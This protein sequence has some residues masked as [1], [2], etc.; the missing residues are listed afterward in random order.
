MKAMNNSLNKMLPKKGVGQEDE[1]KVANKA[2]K[3]A[4]K[5]VF[6]LLQ[7]QFLVS[8][9]SQELCTSVEDLL[10]KFPSFAEADSS[11]LD[12]LVK[13]YNFMI[14]ALKLIEADN[15]KEK[16]LYI[17]GVLSV[18]KAIKYITGTGQSVFVSRRVE[19]YERLGNITPKPSKKGTKRS[20]SE[21]DS[22]SCDSGASSKRS[23]S[24][25]LS[26]YSSGYSSEELEF[27]DDIVELLHAFVAPH[28]GASSST[29]ASLPVEIAENEIEIDADLLDSACE[30]FEFDPELFDL[31]D[32]SVSL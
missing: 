18:G 27:D 19:I 32:L 13:F 24:S 16:L 25:D 6:A 30:L 29:S 26:G 2:A 11:E 28:E 10:Q 1:R 4:L 7:Y 14:A 31:E 8:I 9:N 21:T 12:L 15:N 17:C 20:Q 23:R 22:E 5:V 3:D